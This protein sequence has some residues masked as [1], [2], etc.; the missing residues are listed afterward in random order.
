MTGSRHVEYDPL[1]RAR[2][3]LA[4]DHSEAGTVLAISE[5]AIGDR[6]DVNK[7]LFNE[8]SSGWGEGRRVASIPLVVWEELKRNGI[9]DDKKKLKAWLNHPDNRAFRTRPGK[10]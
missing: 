5:Q 1:T 4:A 6:L 3:I 2:Q 7:A 9:A 10:V 8:P